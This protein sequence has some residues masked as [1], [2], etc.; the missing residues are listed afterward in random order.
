MTLCKCTPPPA[1][2][3][4][5]LRIT[6]GILNCLDKHK[7]QQ[8][9]ETLSYGYVSTLKSLD[10]NIATD[11][12]LNRPN[13]VE[14]LITHYTLHITHYTLHITH[15]TLHITH[16]TLLITPYT[17][18]ITHYT[19]LSTLAEPENNQQVDFH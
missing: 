1:T 19:L 16:Y 4:R 11:C 14:L 18:H 7:L 6:K 10:V 13:T 17:L 15:Y 2:A 9:R 12:A 5:L 3:W 8:G